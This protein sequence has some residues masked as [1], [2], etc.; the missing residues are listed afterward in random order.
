M[1]KILGI[2]QLVKFC[3]KKNSD[4]CILLS[5]I[6]H[7]HHITSSVTTMCGFSTLCRGPVA[8]SPW[9]SGKLL[10]AL[11]RIFSCVFPFL[12]WYEFSG[13]SLHQRFV[14]CCSRNCHRFPNY[15]MWVPH[16]GLKQRKASWLVHMIGFHTYTT[17]QPPF[18][19]TGFLPVVHNYEGREGH[20]GIFSLR[21]GQ[22]IR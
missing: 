11:T 15:E 7:K 3:I 12:R 14:N 6:Q 8:I 2:L 20:M 13:N 4:V 18:S 17:I 19:M 10:C 9:N 21:V 16:K 5:P 1:V 22:I